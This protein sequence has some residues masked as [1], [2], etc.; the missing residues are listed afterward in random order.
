[1]PQKYTGFDQP[2][3]EEEEGKMDLT[4]Q[5]EGNL[6]KRPGKAGKANDITP[7]NYLVYKS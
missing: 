6:A 4:D 3:G 2:S 5:R 1:M 7:E